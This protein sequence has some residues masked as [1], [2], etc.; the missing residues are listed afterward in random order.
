ML[1]ARAL[2]KSASEVHIWSSKV[3]CTEGGGLRGLTQHR[4]ACEWESL[5][6]SETRRLS[7]KGEETVKKVGRAPSAFQLA[8]LDTNQSTK[9]FSSASSGPFRSRSK[10]HPQ[11]LAFRSSSSLC[12]WCHLVGIRSL[13]VGFSGPMQPR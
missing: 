7:G 9:A 8:R 4:A 10:L 13:P 3:C 5:A 12:A 6:S 2:P 1:K 11:R